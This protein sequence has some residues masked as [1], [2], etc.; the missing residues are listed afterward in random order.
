M[1]ESLQADDIREAVR[2]RGRPKSMVS[3]AALLIAGTLTFTMGI[4]RLFFV[5]A[6]AWTFLI[7]GALLLYGHVIDIGTVYEVSDEG[8]VIR[9]PLRFW[10]IARKW[11]WGNMT[12]LD[13]VVRR[14]E[15]SQED[16]DLQVHYTPEDSTVL[17]REDLPFIPELAEEI[18]SR[19]G[20][21]PERRQAM[22]S[23]DSIPQDEKGSYTWN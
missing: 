12:R 5:E 19:A 18:A 22:Q 13:V 7:W 21:T 20:L 6:I 9:S 4:D 23:F 8:F 17:F 3:A 2:F 14:R 16:V 1:A 11:E 15:A 10:A